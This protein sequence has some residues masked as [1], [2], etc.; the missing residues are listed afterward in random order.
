M[1]RVMNLAGGIVLLAATAAAADTPP[2][3]KVFQGQCAICHSA[4]AGGKK[5][6]P[7]LFGVVGRA[8]GTMEGY[9]YSAAMKKA[10]LTWSP[11]EL[12]TYLAAP[13]KAV[14]GTKMM[15]PGL[16]DAAKLDAI[17]KYLATLK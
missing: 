13:A 2:G 17:I 14:P 3:Q 6:G 1:A 9:T 11:A 4:V 5:N 12:T 15:Y 10:G 8:S 16:H 7:S